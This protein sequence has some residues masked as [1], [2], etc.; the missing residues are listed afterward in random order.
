MK[1]KIF[2]DAE[3]EKACICPGIYPVWFF[4][5]RDVLI[6]QEKR[7]CSQTNSIGFHTLR[8]TVF[9]KQRP[10]WVVPRVAVMGAQKLEASLSPWM[11]DAG[12]MGPKGNASKICRREREGYNV[13]IIEVSLV[14]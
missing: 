8:K 12:K 4:L 2:G 5:H 14:T 11:R 13:H 6:L 7:V 3:K 1:K 9:E 10:W